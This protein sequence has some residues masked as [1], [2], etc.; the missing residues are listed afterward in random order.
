[1]KKFVQWLKDAW[2][3]IWNRNTLVHGCGAAA[4]S[5]ALF[6]IFST[7]VWEFPAWSTVVLAAVGA[8]VAGFA[9]ELVQFILK[10]GW[11]WTE[12]KKDL[13]RDA[14]GV[15]VSFVPMGIYLFN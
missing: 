15:L 13:I 2:A 1:M 8:M 4:V 9:V 7:P 12:A 6:V 3:L 11:T 10:E 14:L 5:L